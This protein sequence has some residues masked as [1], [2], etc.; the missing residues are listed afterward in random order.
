MPLH[1]GGSCPDVNLGG[2]QPATCDSGVCPY[3]TAGRATSDGGACPYGKRGEPLRKD[4]ACLGP[5]CQVSTDLPGL[6]WHMLLGSDF[7]WEYVLAAVAATYRCPSNTSLWSWRACF[8][9]LL[10]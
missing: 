5:P 6:P 10:F 8:S 4:G 3:V 7:I 9:R 2:G 1:E